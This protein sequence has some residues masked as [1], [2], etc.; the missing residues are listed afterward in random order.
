MYHCITSR[1][2]T[3]IVRRPLLPLS[4]SLFLAAIY[5]SSYFRG[6]NQNH[7]SN[8]R[9]CRSYRTWETTLDACHWEEVGSNN[10]HHWQALPCKIVHPRDSSLFQMTMQSLGGTS[11]TSL[12]TV[13]ACRTIGSLWI[14]IRTC[15]GVQSPNKLSMN[16]EWTDRT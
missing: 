6:G 13:L 4:P 3:I 14:L 10:A 1:T 12:P 15:W 9:R 11:E 2:A 16:G 7:T 5:L 8:E